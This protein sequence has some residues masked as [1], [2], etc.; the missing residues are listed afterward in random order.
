[1]SDKVFDFLQERYHILASK[2]YKERCEDDDNNPDVDYTFFKMISRELIAESIDDE[3]FFIFK[4]DV[5]KE[6]KYPM[7]PLYKTLTNN[8]LQWIIYSKYPWSETRPDN[9]NEII[10]DFN[11]HLNAL[12][13]NFKK[14]LMSL[15][16]EDLS[17]KQNTENDLVGKCSENCTHPT[18]KQLQDNLSVI[19]SDNSLSSFI[20]DSL[21][22]TE[23]DSSIEIP[24]HEHVSNKFTNNLKEIDNNMI[25]IFRTLQKEHILKLLGIRKTVGSTELLPP[26]L[27]VLWQ[28]YCKIH[29]P[30]SKLMVGARALS[31]HCHRSSD[32]WWGNSLGT[33]NNKNEHA[34]NILQKVFVDISWI[35]IHILPHDVIV[36]EVRCSQGY[37]LRWSHD[38]NFFRGFLEPNMVDG[39]DKKWKH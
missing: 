35:N 22:D 6:N 19:T 18:L 26:P 32:C 2:Y 14:L 3:G 15:Q 13:Y 20:E 30:K 38:G 5:L 37:G 11:Q 10:V 34:V 16:L 28:S 36:L 33:E 12:F 17:S 1:M 23:T 7:H 25:E 27:L 31:K 21:I 29:H 8:L 9:I 4:H 39:H 24:N